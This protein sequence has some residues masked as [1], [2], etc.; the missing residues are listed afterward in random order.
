MGLS[1]IVAANLSIPEG[2]RFEV[3]LQSDTAG[4]AAHYGYLTDTAMARIAETVLSGRWQQALVAM[5]AFHPETPAEVLE[6]LAASPSEVIRATVASSPTVPDS[7]LDA[8]ARDSQ[9]DVRR[10]AAAELARRSS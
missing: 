8:L 9:P 6:E 10:A 2:V 3:W 5:V 7:V 1:G 4:L